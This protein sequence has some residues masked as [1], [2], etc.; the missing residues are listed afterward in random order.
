MYSKRVNFSCLGWINK[1]INE[2][3]VI[4]YGKFSKKGWIEKS[5][6]NVGAEL[7]PF[8]PLQHVNTFS[9]LSK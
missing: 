3:T 5:I 9:I 2:Y 7:Q 8:F 4:N 6:N 1:M